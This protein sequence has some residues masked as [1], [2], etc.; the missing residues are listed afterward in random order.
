[1]LERRKSGCYFLGNFLFT[2]LILA[3]SFI[4]ALWCRFLGGAGPSKPP[5]LFVSLKEIRHQVNTKESVSVFLELQQRPSPAAN[6]SGQKKGPD[7]CS[8]SVNI[9]YSK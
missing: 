3:S 1:M 2:F 8:D 4:Y 9:L 5:G 7:S 6:S